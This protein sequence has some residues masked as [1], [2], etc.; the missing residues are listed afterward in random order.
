VLTAATIAQAVGSVANV[1]PALPPAKLVEQEV[2]RR[3]RVPHRSH[4][5][6]GAELIVSGGGVHNPGIMAHLAALL[7]GLSISTSGDHGI[8]PDAKEA[9]A[10]AVLAWQTWHR[11][12]GNLP[13][14]TGA[15]R[16]VV[17]G[18]ITP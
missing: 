15:R 6:A 8:D 17:L 7:P 5:T 16:A 14:A 1:G 10:F 11:K 12:A 9:I 3:K 18:S 2:G 13:S 4:G